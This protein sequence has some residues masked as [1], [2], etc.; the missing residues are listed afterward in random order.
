MYPDLFG[1]PGDGDSF[2]RVK[3]G[4]FKTKIAVKHEASEKLLLMSS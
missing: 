4:T 1:G 3:F 2:K